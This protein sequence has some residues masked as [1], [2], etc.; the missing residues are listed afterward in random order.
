MA[1]TV[2]GGT[3]IKGFVVSVDDEFSVDG[4]VVYTVNAVNVVRATNEATLSGAEPNQTLTAGGL[5]YALNS[6]QG[7]VSV[8]PAGVTFNTG[9]NQFTATV[10]ATPVTYI[11]T[12]TTA[13]DDR[14]PQNTFPVTSAGS[15]RTFTDSASGVTFSF[16]SGGNNPVTASFPYTN[17][18][19]IDAITGTTFYIDEA[20]NKVEALS[21]LPENDAVRVHSPADGN[22]YLIHYND[23]RV[24]F[25]VISGAN[26]NA[27]VATVGSDIFTVDIDEIDPIASAARR[28]RST[29]TLRDQ[30]QPVYHRRN[31]G[32]GRLLVVHAWSATRRRHGRSS[33][34]TRSS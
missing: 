29:G 25:P 3:V 10:N 4:N 7:Q 18:F 9:T 17:H 11:V 6:A 26:V 2:R 32:W 20:D 28:S 22:T 19:F 13:T 1:Y 16:D 23:V 8:Q 12:A 34:R 31:A 30:R 24:V 14:H 15:Q 5:T 21:Y 33:R 27:G